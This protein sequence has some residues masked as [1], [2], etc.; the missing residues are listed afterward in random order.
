MVHVISVCS[1]ITKQEKYHVSRQALTSLATCLLTWFPVAFCCFRFGPCPLPSTFSLLPT[2]PSL[3]PLLLQT[4]LFLSMPVN[5]RKQLHTLL[6]H[7]TVVSYWAS[8][9][10]HMIL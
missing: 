6:S 8:K 9:F 1:S 4:F 2:F 3:S 5:N 7:F 10:V